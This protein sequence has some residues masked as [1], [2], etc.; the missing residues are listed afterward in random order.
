MNLSDELYSD[1]KVIASTNTQDIYSRFPK[2]S[3][4]RL[5]WNQQVQASSYKNSKSMKWHPLFIKWCLYLKHIS[6]KSYEHLRQS[7]CL[8]LPSQATLRDYTDYIPAKI[9]FCTEVDRDLLDVAFL[10]NELNRYVMII[11]DEVHIR[12]ELVYDKH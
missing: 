3:F 10:N 8:K 12:N 5:F 2:D 9:G 11:M 1:I 4:Q 6:G 7:G